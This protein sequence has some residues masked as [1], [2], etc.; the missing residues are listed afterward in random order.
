MFE[1]SSE[2]IFL[3]HID[4]CLTHSCAIRALAIID[5]ILPQC[6]AHSKLSINMINK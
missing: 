5:G 3:K 1:G 6:F 2:L 4:Q